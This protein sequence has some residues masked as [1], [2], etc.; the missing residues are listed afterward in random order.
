MYLF[1]LLLCLYP[2]VSSDPLENGLEDFHK[3]TLY[4]WVF[5]VFYV[6]YFL[7]IEHYFN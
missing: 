3:I 6:V 1:I 7:N 5:A 4:F 2:A